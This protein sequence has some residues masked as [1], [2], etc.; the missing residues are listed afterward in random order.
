ML[1]ILKRKSEKSRLEDSQATAVRDYE[2]KYRGSI[3]PPTCVPINTLSARESIVLTNMSKLI[4]NIYEEL[5]QVK[6]GPLTTCSLETLYDFFEN[7]PSR[8]NDGDNPLFVA[9]LEIMQTRE[10]EKQELTDES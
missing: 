1:K 4:T 8:D 7:T 10:N 2:I 6:N 5:R 3:C 9:L